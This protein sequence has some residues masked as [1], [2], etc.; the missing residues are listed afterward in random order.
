MIRSTAGV[1]TSAQPAWESEDLRC[2]SP[3][4]FLHVL[5]LLDEAVSFVV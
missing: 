5:F 2:R 4:H 3:G 1:E